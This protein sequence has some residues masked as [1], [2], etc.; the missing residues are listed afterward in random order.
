MTEQ[1]VWFSKLPL[2]SVKAEFF[3]N[4]SVNKDFTRAGRCGRV[5]R[6]AEETFL[7]LTF[8]G[9]GRGGLGIIRT[10]LT[11]LARYRWLEVA[12][13]ASCTGERRCVLV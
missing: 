7:T 1:L 13:L 8:S 2:M 9:T 5:R 6:G 10:M 11:Q 3:R 4:M 12:W